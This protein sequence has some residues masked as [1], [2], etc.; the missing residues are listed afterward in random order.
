METPQLYHTKYNVKS[1]K[2]DKS[3]HYKIGFFSVEIVDFIESFRSGVGWTVK[4]VL[5]LLVGCIKGKSAIHFAGVYSERMRSLASQSFWVLGYFASNVG[6]DEEL[7]RNYI[8]H[9]V[10]KHE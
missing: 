7:I 2:N 1:M 3:R 4:P 10:Q 5:S 8:R 9:L 6:R